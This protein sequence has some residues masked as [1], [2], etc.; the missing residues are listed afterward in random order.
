MWGGAFECVCVIECGVSAGGE[1]A[2]AKLKIGF[3]SLQVY[4]YY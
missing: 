1:G 4:S 2:Q 3:F